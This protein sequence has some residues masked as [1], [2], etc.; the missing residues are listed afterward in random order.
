[1]F[2]DKSKEKNQRESSVDFVGLAKANT[3]VAIFFSLFVILFFILVAI[4]DGNFK[5]NPLIKENQI[6]VYEA[7]SGMKGIFLAENFSK[8]IKISEQNINSGMKGIFLATIYTKPLSAKTSAINK[9]VIASSEFARIEK[10]EAKT[11]LFVSVS[12][13]EK[14]ENILAIDV[15]KEIFNSL[16]R[17]IALENQL[18]NLKNLRNDSAKNLEII[19][20][21]RQTTASDYEKSKADSDNKQKSFFQEFDQFN[22]HNS[23]I[24]FNEFIEIKKD[25]TEQR[26]NLGVLLS[27]EKKFDYLI[28]KIDKKIYE[29]EVNREAIILGVRC[30]NAVR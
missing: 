25:N 16:D 5:K 28:P 9:G 13:L 21:K 18:N 30:A 11:D 22:S 1:M 26:A 23:E 10:E 19:R 15:N 29:I 17:G 14:L 24:L 27:L 12:L 6:Q 4:F 8:P 20:S 7:N 2:L 3:L